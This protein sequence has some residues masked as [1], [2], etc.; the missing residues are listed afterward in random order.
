VRYL[1]PMAPLAIVWVSAL[2]EGGRRMRAV[3]YVGLFAQA[4]AVASVHPHELSYFNVFA[5]GPSGGKRI[6]AD[7][8]LDWGQGAKRL[9]HLQRTRPDFRD[10]TLYYFGD[11]DP[12]HYGVTGRRHVIDAGAL[13]PNLPRAFEA[14][15]A[16]VAVSTSLQFGPWGP[17]G[18]FR[19]LDGVEPVAVLPD[20]TIAIYR[21]GEV[22]GL[23]RSARRMR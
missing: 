16:F 6:L 14:D 5:G 19:A 22:V 15:T 20:Q 12:A 23:K 3:A 4:L 18:Y 21:A 17:P 11:I 9:A 1:L 10:L 13:H 2:A 8:N 7:S